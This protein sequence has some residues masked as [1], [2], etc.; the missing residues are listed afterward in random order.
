VFPLRTV[1]SVV[2]V[3]ALL[4]AQR[5]VAQQTVSFSTQDGGRICADVYGKGARAVVLAHGGRFTK[6]SWRPQ[7][8]LL[9]SKGFE[10]L[11]FDFRGFGCS[12]GPGDKDMFT[13]PMENDVLAAVRYLK[14]HGAKTVSAI[15]GSFG[16]TATGNASIKSTPGEIDRIVLLAGAPSLPADQLKSRTLFIVARDDANDDGPRLPGIRSQFLRAPQPKELI[17]LDGSAH[18]QFL[19]QTDQGDRVMNEILRFLSAP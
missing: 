19:F 2:A 7:A 3:I 13:A 6:E 1:L 16:G 12:T 9:A 4:P 11:A 15:G 14:E 18:A 8:E 10:V 5:V 17:V